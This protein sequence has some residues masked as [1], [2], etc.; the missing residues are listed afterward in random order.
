MYSY[1]IDE[2]ITEIGYPTEPVTIDEAKAYARVDVTSAIQDTLFEYWIKAARQAIEQMTGLSLV[3]KNVVAEIQNWQGNMEL[4][5]GPITSTIAWKDFNGNVPTVIIEG[6]QFPRIPIPCGYLKATY[7]AGY[8]DNVPTELK[9][10]ILNQVTSWYEN[11]GD[12]ATLNMPASVVT[13]CQ[14]Y[15][16]TGLIM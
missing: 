8:T 11:R 9:I 15:S 3:P 6:N 1:V 7:T 2:T 14:K 10:A 13:I 4:P 16:R 12:E 5:Y